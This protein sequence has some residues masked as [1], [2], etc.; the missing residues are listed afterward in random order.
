MRCPVLI[1][2][3]VDWGLLKWKHG[4]HG[5]GRNGCMCDLCTPEFMAISLSIGG[6]KCV[7]VVLVKLF[8]PAV[9]SGLALCGVRRKVHA[10][11]RACSLLSV[12]L[13]GNGEGVAFVDLLTGI[14]R[15]RRVFPGT[16]STKHPGDR[17]QGCMD[18]WNLEQNCFSKIP[19]I[20]NWTM[21]IY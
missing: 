7:L 16:S 15:T 1:Y 20:A 2:I 9:V 21:L 17:D 13:L 10:D 8:W 19:F 3:P 18:C 11:C 6:E 12:N 4:F 5:P 14:T